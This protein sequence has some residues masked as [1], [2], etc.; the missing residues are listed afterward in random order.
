MKYKVTHHNIRIEVPETQVEETSLA[1]LK[2]MVP[3]VTQKLYFV[4][5]SGS[6]YPSLESEAERRTDFAMLD[7]ND[8]RKTL[9]NKARIVHGD[10][11]LYIAPNF[12]GPLSIKKWT[13]VCR[14]I[15]EILE[16]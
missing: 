14:S 3:G 2:S 5:R 16:K 1:I 11:A 7:A 13:A 6:A 12:H 4:G 10:D 9:V 8:S 15:E